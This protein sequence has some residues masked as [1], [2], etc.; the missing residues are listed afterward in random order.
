MADCF[1]PHTRRRIMRAIGRSRTAP[2]QIVA[3]ALAGAGLPFRRNV[4][5]LPGRPDFFVPQTNAGFWRRKIAANRRRDRRVTRTL[6]ARGLTVFTLWECELA[7]VGLP[8]RFLA[9]LHDQIVAG[10]RPGGSP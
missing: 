7:T 1:A 4:A 5:N 8:K 6:R 10:G 2:E 3:T 9:R